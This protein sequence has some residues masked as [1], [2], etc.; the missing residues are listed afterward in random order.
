MNDLTLIIP[1]KNEKDSLPIVLN[2]ISNLGCK[3][4]V[5]LKKDDIET[6]SAIKNKNIDL[7][8]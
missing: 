6:I 7:Y 8:Y 5:S 3:I 1:A 4:T 2:D